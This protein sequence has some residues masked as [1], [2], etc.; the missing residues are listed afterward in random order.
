MSI[1]LNILVKAGGRNLRSTILAFVLP[2]VFLVGC[3]SSLPQILQQSLSVVA[4]HKV[5]FTEL[6]YYAKRSYAAYSPESAIREQFP[7]TTRV[8]TIKS[9]D[10]LYFVETDRKLKRQTISVRGTANKPN[11]WQDVEAR[12]VK[13]S[14]LGIY[15]HRGFRN[16][17]MKVHKDIKQYIKK[18]YSIR[19]TGHSLGGGVAMI[20]AGY[21]HKHGYNVERLVTFGQPKVTNKGGE[22]FFIDGLTRVAHDDDVV[23]ML[24][25]STFQLLA[26]GRYE[27]MGPELILR[28]GP[29]YV[30]LPSHDAD[31][32]SVGELWRNLTN[33]TTKQHHMA[34]YLGNIQEKIKNGSRQVPYLGAPLS[35]AQQ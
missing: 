35:V 3:A 6:E 33:F 11:F 21:L 4:P 18:G 5:D 1:T 19:V 12:M 34:S 17:A 16:D 15:L 25:P 13:D 22:T 20:L 8:I 27:H 30:Y 9:I 24:P 14:V 7:Q 31:R 29:N 23:P 32:L 26:G 28:S 10:V 2:M